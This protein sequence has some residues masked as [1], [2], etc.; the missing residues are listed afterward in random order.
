LVRLQALKVSQ[1]RF[2]SDSESLITAVVDDA[3]KGTRAE[4][5][6]RGLTSPGK[7]TW[8]SIAGVVT[9]LALVGVAAI[10]FFHPPV[11]TTPLERATKDHPW[12]NSLGMKFVPVA[13]T[14]VLFSIWDTRVEDFRAFVDG[15]HYDATGKD[16]TGKMWSLTKDGFQQRGAT[17]KEPGF[18][19][20]PTHPVVGVSWDDAEEFC[21][22]LTNKERDSGP[23]GMYYRLPTDHEWSVAVGLDSEP[24]NTPEEYPWGKGWPPPKGSGNYAGEEVKNGDWPRD[25]PSYLKVID[26]YNDGYPRTSPVGQFAV[27]KNGLYDMGGNVWQWCDDS[28]NS[29]NKERV[30]RGASWGDGTAERLLASFRWNLTSGVRYSRVGFRCVVAWE[31]SR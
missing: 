22:W 28:Y 1:D 31:S 2:R 29:E 19:Q 20:D 25:W 6:K 7:R 15:D 14:K 23:K 18:K 11:I 12:V 21:K 3:L 26:G 13:G 24:G 8:L 16:A 4:R 5:R 27:N 9:V 10:Y 30:S 17:W